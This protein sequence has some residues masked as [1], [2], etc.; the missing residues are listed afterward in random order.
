M[1]CKLI[2]K[3]CKEEVL[4]GVIVATVQC[5]NDT[6]LS[7]VPYLLNLFLD[8]YKDVQELGDRISLLMVDNDDSTKR[9]EGNH[10]FT[11]M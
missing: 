3:C 1:E 5:A 4:I 8:D 6:T 7:W 2:C 10:I 11:L 9:V